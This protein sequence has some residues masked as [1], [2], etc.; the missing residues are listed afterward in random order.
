MPNP[1]AQTAIDLVKA[2]SNLRL[3]KKLLELDYETEMRSWT[4][5][6]EGSD[7][8]SDDESDGAAAQGGGAAAA[9]AT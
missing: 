3:E 6:P 4:T 5:Q 8:E 1:Y 7:D 2:G 9:M